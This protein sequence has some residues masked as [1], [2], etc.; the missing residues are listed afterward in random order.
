MAGAA[1]TK[2]LLNVLEHKLVQE[3]GTSVG[4]VMGVPAG[5]KDDL[6]TD[7]RG[8]KGKIGLIESG[9]WGGSQDERPRKTSRP[10]ESAQIRLLPWSRS[11]QT[12]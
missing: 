7:I 10:K 11:E 1:T 2:A 6:A 8:L 5:R 12:R 9:T 3:V 4:V